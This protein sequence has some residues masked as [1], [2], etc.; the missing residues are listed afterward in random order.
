VPSP[1]SGGCFGQ[2]D[3]GAGTFA[4]ICTHN[5]VGPTVMHIHR[6]APGANGPIAFDLGDPASPVQAVWTGMTPADIAD[7][8]AGNLYVN[9]HTGGR[10]EG[11][12]RGQILPRTV[13][14]FAFFANSAQQVPP[15]ISP[16]AG[17]CFADLGDDAAT[18]FIRC[19][20]NVT[21]ATVAHLHDAPAGQNGPV[22]FDFPGGSPFESNVPMSPRL[23][24]DFAAGFLYV[25]VHSVDFPDG[26]IRGQLV[27]A[28]QQAIEVPTLGE[29]GL[30]LLAL[31]LAGLAWRRL[32]A[33][34][35]A[36][37]PDPPA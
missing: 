16:A 27:A 33:A 13:D 9:I 17:Q 28:P 12:I 21:Q 34:T 10:P 37:A 8:L 7:L 4:L 15:V 25:N 26:E 36:A 18:L 23:V 32:A 20:H 24:A 29:W 11:E 3:A 19:T 30:I 6:G 22:V 31:A 14:S 5:V 35:T 2:L 1:A